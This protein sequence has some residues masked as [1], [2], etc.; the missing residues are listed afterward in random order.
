[1]NTRLLRIAKF[2]NQ[3]AQGSSGVTVPEGVQKK[4]RYGSSGHG[5]AGMVVL[6]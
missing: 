5:S 3:A 4:G 2:G 1:M 6:R